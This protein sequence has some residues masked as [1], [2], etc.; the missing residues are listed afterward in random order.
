MHPR[1]LRLEFEVAA[2]VAPIDIRDRLVSAWRGAA[3][4]AGYK[5]DGDP[6]LSV[7][8]DTGKWIVLGAVLPA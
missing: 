8:V 3:S 5:P 1:H 2:D 7:D 6:R 4:A